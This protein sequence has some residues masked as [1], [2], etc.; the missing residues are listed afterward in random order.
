M[1]PY[2]IPAAFEPHSL[3]LAKAREA[4]DCSRKEEGNRPYRLSAL[5]RLASLLHLF[6]IVFAIC[7]CACDFCLDL[8]FTVDQ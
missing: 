1:G 2:C 8:S 5:D 3:W 6:A 4:S 7:I